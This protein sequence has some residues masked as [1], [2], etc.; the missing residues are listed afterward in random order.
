MTA[1]RAEPAGRG[2]VGVYEDNLRQSKDGC[3]D[4]RDKHDAVEDAE[5]Q[6]GRGV[7]LAPSAD[8]LVR[9]DTHTLF[10]IKDE[11]GK[12]SLVGEGK[13]NRINGEVPERSNGATC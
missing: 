7:G 10:I 6:L 9:M 5:P 4:A 12:V 13:K 1:P 11:N 2:V 3:H 8:R